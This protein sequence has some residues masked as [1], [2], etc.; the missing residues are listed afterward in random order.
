M[1]K[2]LI[3]DGNSILNRA[4]YGIRHL[5]TKS[6]L[7]TNA[8]YGFVRIL[9]RHFDAV[10]PDY[11]ACAF[12]MR[13]PTF[14]H[15][16]SEKY[17]ANRKGMPE[18]LALQLPYSHRLAEAMGFH[19]AE[20][21]GYEGDDLIGT[22]ARVG[23][24]EDI[25]AYILTGDRDSLQLLSEKVSV[26]L[27]K[28][29]EDVL[30]T[31]E[32]FTEEYGISPG[33]FVDVKAL[34]GDSSDNIPGVAGIGEKTALKLISASGSLDGLYADMSSSGAS[35][36]I[37]E[38]LEGGRE[39]AFLSRK[40][41]QI[42]CA[43]PGIDSAEPYRTEGAIRSSLSALFGE[44]EFT[45]MF[46]L[47]GISASDK[48][49]D[50]ECASCANEHSP[51]P[52]AAS[53]AELISHAGEENC[54]S[55][56]EENAVVKVSLFSNC[57]IFTSC[58]SAED[59]AP[60]VERPVICHDAKKLYSIFS[61]KGIKA[62]IKFDTCLAAYL[63]NPGDKSYE[64][65]R[66]TGHFAPQLPADSSEVWL[67]AGVWKILE[68]KLREEGMLELLCDMEIPLAR[69][70]CDMEHDGILLDT[71]GLHSFAAELGKAEELLAEGIYERAGFKFNLNSPKQLGEVLFEK[72]GLP[73]GRKT[74]T[75][76][77]TDAETLSKLRGYDDII[78]QILS[79]REISK[80]RSTYGE[81]LC[82]QADEN[83]RVHTKFNQCGTATGRLSSNDP[84]MQNIPVRGE[85]GRELR[86]YFC[87]PEGRV[88]IDADYSQIELR[89]LAVISGDKSMCDAFNSGADIH[90][91]TASQVF[92]IPEAEITPELRGRAKAVNFGIVYG[93]GEYSLSQDL[94]ISRREAAEYIA[95]YLATYPQVAEYLDTTVADAKKN[96]YT[97]TVFG[98]RRYIP[99]LSARNKMLQAFGERVAK[100][101][102][103][104]G[105]AADIIKMAM[106][107]VHR[108]LEESGL[109]A[110]LILQ[111]HDEL[112]V[113]SSEA[114]S[115]HA[116]EILRT[117]M[118]S[119]YRCAVELRADVSVG[120]TWLDAKE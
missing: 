8:L 30:Y 116:S 48:A 118:E 15:E 95:G 105:S 26:I 98:R 99:E 41:A 88:L 92:K 40:L 113:E 119:A 86:R 17:K 96:G 42:C 16:L 106:I 62:N 111:V 83:G 71:D 80:L 4:F 32:L 103:I 11:A 14:R 101:S 90:T 19:V 107:D 93:I 59:F 68:D 91:S 20:L 82:A 31:P 21:A 36:K 114:D 58:G 70:L 6:G 7:P 110:R 55:V 9:K 104:Q 73:H 5:S 67:I 35:A 10:K 79:F 18:E 29:K 60:L 76:Y 78:D 3:V 54:L 108:K 97:T 47:F 22:L 72:L 109:D 37:C 45:G 52:K 25:H 39:D 46:S 74:K 89:L 112:I 38:K 2:F 85:L 33:Q 43:V 50:A 66:V 75:G 34:M 56:T 51:E 64:I 13:A 81:A 100:N 23:E 44:L 1:K 117:S 27:T 57:E 28:T 61:P 94:G 69:V 84:N 115:A 65:G 49:E 53:P 87:A 12:D 77:S 102:P 24:K 63:L 120:K